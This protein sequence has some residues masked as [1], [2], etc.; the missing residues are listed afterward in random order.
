MA[1]HELVTEGFQAGQVG[2]ERHAAQD[3]HSFLRTGQRPC[4]RAARAS[5]DG[6]RAR[7]R[8]VE[9]GRRLV[10]PSSA[11]SRCRTR[12]SRPT[13]SSRRS[14]PCWPSSASSRPSCSASWTATCPFLATTKVLV[15]SVRRGVGREVAHEVIKEHAVAVALEMREKG[16]A[17]NDLLA[18]LAA[19]D[20]LRLSAEGP[21]R[22]G[23]RAAD[24]HRCG[25]RPGGRRTRPDRELVA[26]NPEAAA[27]DPA[28]SSE[29]SRGLG[30]RV[31]AQPDAT[32]EAVHLLRPADRD[33]DPAGPVSCLGDRRP[34]RRR[35][36]RP[37]APVSTYV[38]R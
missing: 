22:L 8:P 4:G 30:L 17:D 21:G 14:S 28:P 10:T 18:R 35:R 1:G 24:L 37:D 2:F 33:R 20:R 26:D 7:R 3:E 11:G 29:A 23:G 13:A 19:D 36:T 38:R 34:R 6:Q 27:T 16:A 32:R 12:S 15:A 9:R 5:L 31:S 25:R